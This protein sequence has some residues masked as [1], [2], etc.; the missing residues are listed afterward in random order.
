ML[1]AG[2]SRDR[3]PMRRIFFFFFSNLPNP[4][5]RTMALGSTQPLTTS[6]TNLKKKNWGVKGGRRV[7]LTTLPPSVSRFSKKCGSLDLSQ[8]YGPPLPVTAI[9]LF[10]GQITIH[11]KTAA[12]KKCATQP[13][14]SS[15]EHGNEPSGFRD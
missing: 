2:R 7:V 10:R 13:R 12:Y 3:V 8:P 9:S 4:S 14:S 1:Q 5:G 6:T 11:S 15:R